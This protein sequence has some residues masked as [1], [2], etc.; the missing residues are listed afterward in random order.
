MSALVDELFIPSSSAEIRDQMIR[1]I[2]VGA[3][4]AGII[5]LD[6]SPGS[7]VYIWCSVLSNT[8]LPLY[9]NAA[10]TAAAISEL[11]AE[12][13]QLDIIRQAMGLPEVEPSP[14]TGTII[15]TIPS[16]NTINVLDGTEFVTEAGFRGQV[17][18][19]Q[20]VNNND[21]VSVRLI[22]AGSAGN[23]DPGSR[24][25]FLNPPFGVESLATVN[26]L[27]G[28]TDEE[29]DFRKRERVLNRR[30][31]VPSAGN[32][33][34]IIDLLLNEST[35]LDRV[36][37]Y[38]AL[39]GAGTIAVAITKGFDFVNRDFTRQTT[40]VQI[41]DAKALLDFEIPLA[42]ECFVTSTNDELTNVTIGL[43]MPNGSSQGWTDPTPWPRLTSADGGR[44]TATVT[45]PTNITLSANTNIAPVPGQTR[46]D[47]ICPADQRTVRSRVLS[48]AGSSGAWV[49]TLDKPLVSGNVAIQTGDYVGPAASQSQVIVDNF[50]KEMNQLGCSEMAVNPGRASRVPSDRYF[51]E[52]SLSLLQPLFL[53][54][55]RSVN[56][57]YRSKVNA[58]VPANVAGSPGILIPGRIGLYVL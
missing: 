22:D 43:S 48:V 41:N 11:T 54:E 49:L 16:G 31:N 38:P 47:W 19:D 1:D 52:L 42:I 44:I 50:L 21:L 9:A 18:G 51:D 33:G 4:T 57:L 23:A 10:L 29:D 27:S 34:F 37:V 58:T 2:Q 35:A 3:Y 5:D 8:L 30:R 13:E 53:P 12:G 7:D 36:Y 46:I 39:G 6:V 15:I 55:I 25:V 32:P 40:S 24:V 17:F 45:T 26:E 28:G 56:Y 20:L 14:A